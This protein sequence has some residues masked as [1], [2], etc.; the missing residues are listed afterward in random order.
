MRS[1]YP[2]FRTNPHRPEITIQSCFNTSFCIL[3][4][5]AVFRLYL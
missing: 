3:E 5:D 2:F 1:P 4:H